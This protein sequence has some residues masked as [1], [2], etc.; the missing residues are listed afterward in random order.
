MMM[1]VFCL[2]IFLGLVWM[3]GGFVHA[4]T[5]PK[6]YPSLFKL[7]K[8]G[9]YEKCHEKVAKKV[10]K[11]K[12]SSRLIWLHAL[13]MRCY[14]AEYKSKSTF[15]NLRKAWNA[16]KRMT[17][18]QSGPWDDFVRRGMMEFFENLRTE[19]EKGE[20]KNEQVLADYQ[21]NLFVV[22]K[23]PA[24]AWESYR[25]LMSGDNH[26]LAYQVLKEGLALQRDWNKSYPEL[27]PAW[28]EFLKTAVDNNDAQTLC[29]WF[30]AAMRL[31][32]A[33]DS[34][35]TQALRGFTGNSI[36][37]SV[38]N[39]GDVNRFLDT[40]EKYSC[41]IHAARENWEIALLNEYAGQGE[42]DK[43]L[44]YAE[45]LEKRIPQT[46][47]SGWCAHW[48]QDQTGQT[49]ADSVR[50]RVYW[51]RCGKKT[52][53]GKWA[54]AK[55]L[56]AGLQAGGRFGQAL[57][58]AET[59]QLMFPSEKAESKMLMEEIKKGMA[60]FLKKNIAVN[61]NSILDFYRLNAKTTANKALFVQYTVRYVQAQ[62][63]V[64]NFSECMR[65]MKTALK[66]F[67]EEPQLLKVQKEWVWA[68]YKK[69]FGAG[70]KSF[71]A[72]VVGMDSKTC[73]EGKVADSS[74]AQF[75]SILNY[76]RRLA[77]LY[78]SCELD[79]KMNFYAQKAALIM[80]ANS[81]LT[82]SPEKTAL[83]WSEEGAKGAGSSNLSLGHNGTNALLG[84][85]DDDGGNNSA[86][87]HRRWILNPSNS[88]FGTG[89]GPAT[90]AL[91]VFGRQKS[92]IDNPYSDT[93]DFVAWPAPVAFPQA[94]VPARWSFSLRGAD[95]T[96]AVV[97]MTCD[98]KPVTLN[99]EHRNGGYGLPAIVWSPVLPAGCTRIEVTVSGVNVL[100]KGSWSERET[101]RFRYPI[102]L[103]K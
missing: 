85:V 22:F 48:V 27:T 103:L 24:S 26:Y 8:Q 44:E 90:M 102:T 13:D 100:K 52:T 19:S 68:D 36:A 80:H 11:S 7:Y 62:M 86:V 3:P 61:R 92:G 66:L 94:L 42:L 49:R 21:K 72:R 96:N 97:S 12:S 64:E 87:G 31:N 34:F 25:Y 81:Y 65:M 60:A 88:V 18:N 70:Y 55:N 1:R 14:N 9:K 93:A 32:P 50:L 63:M 71:A 46:F 23:D 37:A 51:Q 74:M 101:T 98:G 5:G 30:P 4:Q 29:L 84:Q 77:G 83:C 95:F 40:A 53:P 43:A 69:H 82:H 91:Y 35:C 45:K 89:S 73:R 2:H 67:P 15:S 38:W 17:K 54:S 79:K 58:L 78:D 56:I 20:T 33:N 59:L 10:G 75:L 76:V 41:N 47:D 6:P 57:S 39:T 16:G 28:Q 99:I